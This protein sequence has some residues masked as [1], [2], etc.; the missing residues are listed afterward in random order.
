M[1]QERGGPDGFAAGGQAQPC[2][3][4]VEDR[5]GV[6]DA[7]DPAEHLRRQRQPD[8]GGDGVQVVVLVD[9]A[10]PVGADE[11]PRQ[12][13]PPAPGRHPR[14]LRPP[15]HERNPRRAQQHHPTRQ[16]PRPRLQEHGPPLHHDL[17]D[18]RQTRPQ[19]SH[20]LTGFT[21]TKQRK[22]KKTMDSAFSRTTAA[23]NVC[24]GRDNTKGSSERQS[25]ALL[26]GMLAVRRV[27]RHGG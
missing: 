11:G 2:E 17:P 5:T 26:A 12:T 27:L 21:H 13:V 22:A 18:L 8:G 3:T 19:N 7:R 20:R 1:A 14:L 4:T 10:F 23:K 24:G 9:D 6:R 15:I 25:L 16:D